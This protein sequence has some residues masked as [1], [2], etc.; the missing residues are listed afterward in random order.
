MLE[1]EARDLAKDISAS[2]LEEFR[3]PTMKEKPALTLSQKL[4]PL[5]PIMPTYGGSPYLKYKETK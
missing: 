5:Q 4:E 3:S 1:K 2:F